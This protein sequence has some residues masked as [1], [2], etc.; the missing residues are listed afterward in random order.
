M[1]SV[2]IKHKLCLLIRVMNFITLLCVA[3][4]G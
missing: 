3:A 1:F 4:N 2:M